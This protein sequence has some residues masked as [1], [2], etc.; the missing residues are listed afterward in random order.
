MHPTYPQRVDAEHMEERYRAPLEQIS[1]HGCWRNGHAL[2]WSEVASDTYL[3][4]CAWPGCAAHGV[5]DGRDDA[6]I[7][8]IARSLH[9]PCGST[10]GG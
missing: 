10:R 3:G 6:G 8:V 4:Q 5:I 9:R 1:Q 2:I 7:L